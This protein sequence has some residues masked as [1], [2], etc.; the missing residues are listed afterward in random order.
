MSSL[1]F[2]TEERQVFVATDTL[3]VAPGGRPLM[4]T[5]KALIVPHLRMVMAGTGTGGVLDRWFVSVNGGKVV[6]GIE[7][8]DYHTPKS[9]SDLWQRFKDERD[10]FPE[11][12]TTTVYH[13]GFSEASGSIRAFAYRSANGFE[14]EPLGY[15]I[16][17][18]PE[19]SVP[20]NLQLPG[21]LKS[22]M[23][24]QRAVQRGLPESDRVYIGGEIQV[25]HLMESGFNVYTL[26]RFDD[27]A[28]DAV[29]MFNA[30]RK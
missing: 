13:F 22:M 3:A 17:V 24:E 10:E 7:N 26:D 28:A 4:F 2:Q 6:T 21:D 20:Q 18:K 27:F 8:L 11:G 1:I 12:Q 23:E 9:L 16:A 30:F 29:T 14:S 25:H 5:T 19:C 15:G